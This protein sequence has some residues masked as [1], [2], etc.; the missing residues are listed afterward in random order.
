MGDKEEKVTQKGA[1][2]KKETRTTKPSNPR[3]N[4]VERFFQPV[5]EYLFIRDQSYSM[6]NLQV[7]GETVH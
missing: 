2:P 5:M 6:A 7:K 4:L 1:D 3:K